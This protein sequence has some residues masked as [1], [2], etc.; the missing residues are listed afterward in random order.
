[1]RRGGGGGFNNVNIPNSYSCH[2]VLEAASSSGTPTRNNL[3]YPAAAAVSP[4]NFYAATDI[5]KVQGE[6]LQKSLRPASDRGGGGILLLCK[7]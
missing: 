3:V 6:R 5:F 2:E 7:K 4:N 1:M